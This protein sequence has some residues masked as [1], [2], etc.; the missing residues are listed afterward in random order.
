MAAETAS[1]SAAEAADRACI[2]QIMKFAANL[3]MTYGEEDPAFFRG[4]KIEEAQE[5]AE[6]PTIPL[7]V[8]A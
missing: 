7:P 6:T 2:D 1:S 8:V 5:P 4:N 3:S